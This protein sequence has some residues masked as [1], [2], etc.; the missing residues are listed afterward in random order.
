[1]LF[2]SQNATTWTAD[3]Y[4]DMKFIINRARFDNSAATRVSLNNAPLDIGNGGKVKL[5]IDPVITF[6]PQ[7]QLVTNSTTL[8]FTIGA[9]LYQKTTLAEGTIVAIATSSSGVLLTIND[10]SG[11]WQAGSNTGGVI[12]NRI[13]S[14]KTTATMV[15]SSASGDFLVGETIT[16]N[17]ASAPTAEV[18]TW[19]SGTNTLTLRYVSTDFT[20]STETIT[21][22]TSSIT[23]TVSS[24]TYAGDVVEGG[25][26]SDAFVS[27]TPTYTTD[28][29]RVRILHPNHGMHD[30][31]NNVV[32]TGIT[33]EVSDT[34]L[35]SSISASDTSI[36]VND[37]NAFHKLINGAAISTT[38]LGYIKIDDEIISYSAISANG[39]TITANERGLDG[40]TAASHVDESVVELSLI[41]I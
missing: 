19:T 22:G 4:E 27:T 32:L 14:S 13:V 30:T 31:D 37:A 34:Y 6:K 17:S 21:G 20:A 16:G 24:I 9:R 18:V 29:R 15:V 1:M 5:A 3:Q 40:T 12:A 33:S 10:I 11:S 8:P 39:K 2:K 41:H 23:A 7:L 38:N 26:V 36:S 25:A 35:T 28:Q